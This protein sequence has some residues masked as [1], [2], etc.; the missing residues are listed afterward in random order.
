MYQNAS[1][2]RRC[3]RREKWGKKS[4][5]KRRKKTRFLKHIVAGDYIAKTFPLSLHQEGLKYHPIILRCSPYILTCTKFKVHYAVCALKI[6]V[7]IA[8]FLLANQ[9]GKNAFYSKRMHNTASSLQSCNH[10]VYTTFSIYMYV[11]AL[12]YCSRHN[13]T[14]L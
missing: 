6:A 3:N 9:V 13:N 14:F 11:I 2:H 4:I 8:I 5:E 7:K 10:S 1:Y 12:E